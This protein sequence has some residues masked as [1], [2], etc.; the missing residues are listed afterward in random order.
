MNDE[1]KQ[2]EEQLSALADGQLQGQ[3]FEQAMHWAATAQGQATWTTYQVIGDVLRSAE[4]AQHG[5][6]DLLAGIRTRLAQENAAPALMQQPRPPLQSAQLEQV[7]P[8]GRSQAANASVFRWK[9]V[10]GLASLAA[11][12]AL[13]W[14]MALAPAESGGGSL[15]AVSAPATASPAPNHPQAS[16][17]VMLRDPRLDELMAA[18]Q[19]YGATTTLQMPAGFLRNANFAASNR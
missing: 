17:S 16:A 14:H 6:H 11:V 3:E 9:M 8:P 10:A 19:Q 1:L 7:A 2:R 15:V 4:L 13:G 5:H 18:H 12:S